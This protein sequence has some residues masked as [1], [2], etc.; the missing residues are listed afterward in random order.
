MIFLFLYE[1][2]TVFDI[3][4]TET[5]EYSFF[6]NL[7]YLRSGFTY[8]TVF[9]LQCQTLLTENRKTEF[10]SCEKRQFRDSSGSI[11]CL[12]PWDTEQ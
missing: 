8:P 12:L 7:L 2:A 11:A 6:E 1:T 5:L 10:R 9:D 4:N 3:A